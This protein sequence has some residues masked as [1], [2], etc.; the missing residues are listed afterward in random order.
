MKGIGFNPGKAAFHVHSSSRAWVRLRISLIADGLE[1]GSAGVCFDFGEM[2]THGVS[3]VADLSSLVSLAE[4]V[5]LEV[6]VELCELL[7]ASKRQVAQVDE[8]KQSE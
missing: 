8:G 7:S 5:P 1:L 4:E 6:H 3:N 2:E